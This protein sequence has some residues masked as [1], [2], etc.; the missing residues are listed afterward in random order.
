[1]MYTTS[2]YAVLISGRTESKEGLIYVGKSLRV[3]KERLSNMSL[4]DGLSIK[5]LEQTARAVSCIAISEALRGNASLWRVHMTGLKQMIDMRGGLKNFSV[6]LQLKIHRADLMGATDFLTIPIFLKS[7]G[8]LWETAPGA[9]RPAP[10][11]NCLS[12]LPISSQ[13]RGELVSLQTLSQE[14]SNILSS[15]AVL[16]IPQQVDLLTRTCQ[17]RYSILPSERESHL[18]ED[19][20][21]YIEETIRVGALLYIHITPLEFPSSAVGAANLVKRMK[22]LV[23]SVQLWDGIEDVLVVWLLFLACVNARRG[24]DRIWFIVQLEKVLSRVG[25]YEWEVARKQL[26]GLWWV[27][28]LHE[29][30]YKDI[31]DEIVGLRKALEL[32]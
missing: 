26:E 3:V 16:S 32:A 6:S 13:L 20:D 15:P 21:A 12:L 22:D 23:S 19:V 29:K 7:N 17:L 8:V 31:W 5:S 1:L 9:R 14:L 2:T 28:K 11:P 24:E 18:E 4:D 10:S 30:A 27:R 25:L